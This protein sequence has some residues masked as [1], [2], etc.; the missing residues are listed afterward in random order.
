MIGHYENEQ[1]IGHFR[2]TSASLSKRVTVQNLS[3]EDEFD[4]HEN[5]PVGVTRFHINGF[6]LRLV[7][8]QRQ[9]QLGNGLLTLLCCCCCCIF[10][11]TNLF[12]IVTLSTHSLQILEGDYTLTF[13]PNQGWLEPREERSIKLTFTGHKKVADLF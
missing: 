3:Y 2:V 10:A 5:K 9:K 6:A 4:L 1:K 11:I 7:L 13:E 8:T 12:D